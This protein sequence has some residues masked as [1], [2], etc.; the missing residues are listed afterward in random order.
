MRINEIEFNFDDAAIT[1]EILRHEL[2]IDVYHEYRRTHKL[3]NGFTYEAYELF[4]PDVL[5]DII[6]EIE[7]LHREITKIFNEED[8]VYK[9]ISFL[10]DYFTK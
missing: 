9:I 5:N 7:K 3:T 1:Y 10:Y 2:S 8:Q 4:H 6:S